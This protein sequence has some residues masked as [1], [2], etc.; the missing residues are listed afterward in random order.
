MARSA[1]REAV[2][3]YEQARN[4]LTHLPE[5][6]D[7]REQA[8]TLLL[9]LR[10]ALGPIG[11]YKRM[12]ACMREAEALATALDDSHRLAQV[13]SFLSL[14]C[15][16]GGE[17]EQALVVTQRALELAMAGGAVVQQ[18][19]ANR[20]LARA[21]YHQGNYRQAIDCCK[22]AMAALDG[23]SPYERFGAEFLPAVNSCTWLARCHAELGTFAEGRVFGEE[24]LRIAE[25]AAHPASL[26]VASNGLGLLVLLQGNLSRALPLLER[27]VSICQ[28]S[29]FLGL[30]TL[31]AEPLG[32]AYT[33][34]GRLADAV[35]LLTQTLEQLTALE[36][37]D[38]QARC[39]LSLGE[40]HML[41]GH[42]DD[43]HTLAERALTHARTYKEHGNETYALRLLGEI[44]AHR[45][46]PDAA[47]AEAHYRQ[48]LALAEE[49]GMRPLQAH[50][51]RDLG[52][53]YAAT[54]Q[55]EQARAELLAA[56]A[57]YREMAMTFWLPQ[58]EAALA[59]VEEE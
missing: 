37:V 7:M 19:Q 1:N 43:A 32:A 8:L 11:D 57:L 13:L 51:H 10:S 50:C 30:S 54:G 5:T 49:L 12:L 9:A 35:P 28:D 2:E 15:C 24:G 27:A 23:M 31:Q 44:A 14:H 48:A 52:T 34:S 42:L 41:A 53:L 22:Q 29:G 56:L 16:T 26:V 55:R 21:Y 47:Q 3:Y 18:A 36:R 25:A 39:Y 6:R 17:Y 20:F 58:T 40:A 59:Q 4:A 38:F 45:E 46:P 33:L